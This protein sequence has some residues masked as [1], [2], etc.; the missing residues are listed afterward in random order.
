MQLHEYPQGVK[1]LDSSSIFSAHA[2]LSVLS[3]CLGTMQRVE[4]SWSSFPCI[5]NLHVASIKHA[6]PAS[7]SGLDP[8]IRE[9]LVVYTI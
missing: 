9:H 2:E 3:L 1:T 4:A 8:P 5:V 7:G 6:I